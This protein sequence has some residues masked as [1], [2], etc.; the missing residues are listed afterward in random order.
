[1][2]C[3]KSFPC[4][5]WIYFQETVFHSCRPCLPYPTL[6]DP[7]LGCCPGFGFLVTVLHQ[8]KQ[9]GGLRGGVLSGG[10]DIPPQV[11]SIDRNLIQFQKN[12]IASPTGVINGYEE[13]QHHILSL[14]FCTPPS[15]CGNLMVILLRNKVYS[16]PNSICLKGLHPDHS[17]GS[18]WPCRECLSATLLLLALNW[19]WPQ[20]SVLLQVKGKSLFSATDDWTSSPGNHSS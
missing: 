9:M 10:F 6:P 15:P 14:Y 13:E 20:A 4:I 17:S 18:S 2:A 3:R 5:S 11:S 16:F 7:T 1:M 8:S 19:L 12:P